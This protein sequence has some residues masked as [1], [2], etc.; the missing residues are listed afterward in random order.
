MLSY[1]NLDYVKIITDNEKQDDLRKQVE[2]F[3]YLKNFYENEY[4]LNFLIKKFKL[5]IFLNIV[6]FLFYFFLNKNNH[7]RTF[8]MCY[9]LYF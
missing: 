7:K 4:N 6:L 5:N 9:I 3:I 1:N 2:S 8:Q